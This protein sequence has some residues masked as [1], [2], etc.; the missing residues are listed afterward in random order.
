MQSRFYGHSRSHENFVVRYELQTVY[1]K[2]LS[3]G[4]NSIVYNSPR[5][6]HSCLLTVDGRNMVQISLALPRPPRWSRLFGVEDVF[7]GLFALRAGR[8]RANNLK[9]PHKSVKSP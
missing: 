8:S 1:L 9:N 6:R 2:P 5:S 7:S 3:A 4:G